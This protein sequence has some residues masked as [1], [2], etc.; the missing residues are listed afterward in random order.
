MNW[1]LISIVTPS[2]NQAQFL[3]ATIQSVQ[4][5]D[6]PN[7]EYI[8][9]D[10]GS[11]DG[12]VEIIEKY[13]NNITFWVSEPDNGQV[14]AL[15]KGFALSTGEILGWLNSDDVFLHSQVLS[16]VAD[17]FCRY[18]DLHMLTGSGMILDGQGKWLRQIPYVPQYVQ[19]TT[20]RYRNFVLQPAT[21]FHRSI[22]EDTPLDANLHYAFD[23]DFWIRVSQKYNVLSVPNVWAGARWW[24]ENKT[25]KGDPARTLEQAKVFARYSG[26]FTWQ[27]Y[28]LLGFYLGYRF[29]EMF[30]MWIC[31][32]LKKILRLSS[33]VLNRIS[34]GKFPIT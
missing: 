34:L 23:W 8:I 26:K 20:L 16:E 6:Y 14:D 11:R 9:I 32:F 13:A 27:Y 21:F 2:Y 24:G 12:S 30:P 17:I 28:S 31:A 1:P 7:L 22:F 25:A 29:A 10:G 3:E 4:N 15:H 19:A 5:Q 33:L 18:P